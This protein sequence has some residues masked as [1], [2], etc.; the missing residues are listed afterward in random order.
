MAGSLTVITYNSHGSG[1][2]RLEYIKKLLSKSDFVFLQEHWLQECQFQSFFSKLPQIQ[3]HCVSGINS[4]DLSHSGRPH[5]GVAIIWKNNI[6]VKVD[7][8][9]CN[10]VRLC[11]VNVKLQTETIVMVNVYMPS[12]NTSN[13]EELYHDVLA[14]VACISHLYSDSKIILG[15]DFN[16]NLCQDNCNLI[17]HA[18]DIL[19]SCGLVNC[20]M[21]DKFKDSVAYTF[22]SKANHAQS[23]IDFVCI[24]ESASNDLLSITTINECDNFSDHLPLQVKMTFEISNSPAC[25]SLVN[26]G[27][28]I[29][30]KRATNQNLLNYK[31][32]L[33][34]M[35][36]EIP[37]PWD[38]LRCTKCNH[39]HHHQCIQEF[40]DRIVS[41]C[42][43]SAHETIPMSTAKKQMDQATPGWTTYVKPFL[44]QALLWHHIWKVNGSP[45]SGHIADIKNRTRSQYHRAQCTM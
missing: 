44:K 7:P 26:N 36:K 25:D 22:E 24:S 28:Y 3:Y 29:N 6:K 2:G 27:E 21:L 8:I 19:S 42:L 41:A 35:L 38:V 9:K 34:D 4:T 20:L 15:G 32:K 12:S 23:L 43:V 16:I 45:R 11:A 13:R 39:V 18:K 5:G 37:V 10:S 33:S 40:H 17:R 31:T 30:W 1:V 14:E